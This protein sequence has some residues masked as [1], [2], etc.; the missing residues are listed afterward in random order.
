MNAPAIPVIHNVDV[1]THADVAEIRTALARQAAS[2]VQW[3]KTIERMKAEGVTHVVECG[4]G[5][6]LTG[7]IRRIAPRTRDLQHH[8]RRS[9]RGNARSGQG[10]INRKGTLPMEHQIFSN[11][12]LQD[13]VVSHHR[14]L[15][16]DRRRRPRSLRPCWRRRDRHGDLRLGRRTHR[17]RSPKRR[18]GRASC[19]NV[20]DAEASA[21]RCSQDRRR[22]RP[23]R[24]PRQ[25]RRDHARHVGAS[26][27]GRA[28]GRSDRDDLT[29]AFP[30]GARLHPP[31]MK[32]SARAP[33]C[34]DHERRGRGGERHQGELPPPRRRV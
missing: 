23:H 27:E 15:L 3:V 18:R 17:P 5:K 33:S 9:A 25:Q 1:E 16:R 12:A 11:E 8:R 14:R 4:P 22:G 7:M 10:R 6:V 13:R 2:A 31:M 34:L 26:H 32:L 28:V 20:C 21:A 24:R 30:L 29:A 19:W